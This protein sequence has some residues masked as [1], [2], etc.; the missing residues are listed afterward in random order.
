MDTHFRVMRTDVG[1]HPDKLFTLEFRMAGKNY[2]D[3]ERPWVVVINEDMAHQIWPN[4]NLIGQVITIDG[5]E[6]KPREIVG[7]VGNVKEFA[8]RDQPTPQI[9]VSYLQRPRHTD[10][11]ETSRAHKSLVI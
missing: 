3:W 4:Q 6:E 5:L 10:G 1:F 8:L 9:Y 7:V 11:G 2:I